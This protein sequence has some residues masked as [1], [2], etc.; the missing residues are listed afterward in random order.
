MIQGVIG[1]FQH[2]S[3]LNELKSDHRLSTFLKGMQEK[4]ANL[5][6]KCTKIQ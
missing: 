1:N 6:E 4:I 2:T 5:Y 3:K